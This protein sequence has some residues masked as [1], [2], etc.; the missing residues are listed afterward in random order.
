MGMS[1]VHGGHLT[2]GSPVNRSGKHY[3]I[4]WY[5]VDPQTSA[6]ITIRSVSWPGNT[7]RR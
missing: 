5:T 2:H 3:R 4:V 6:W 7:G 1:L